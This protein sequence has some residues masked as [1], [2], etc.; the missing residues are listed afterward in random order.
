MSWTAANID[1]GWIGFDAQAALRKSIGRSVTVLN[2]ADAAGLAEM[3]FG[4]GRGQSGVV[5]ILTL[6]TGVGSALFVD[7][8]LVPNT[9]LG[10]MEIRVRDAEWEDVFLLGDGSLD[11]EHHLVLEHDD[12]VVLANRGL[13]QAL[14]VVRCRREH[15]LDPRNVRDERVQALAVLRG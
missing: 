14:R 13:E 4:A 3:R 2:D 1:K 10:H 7:G 5:L 15:D 8:R 9:E 11:R 6:G 12:G